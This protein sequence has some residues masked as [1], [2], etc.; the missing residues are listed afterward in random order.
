MNLTRFA[1]SNLYRRKTRSLLTLAAIAIGVA[2]IVALTAIAWGFEASWQKANTARGTDLI[3]TKIASENTLPSAFFA[4][5]VSAQLR[6]MPQIHDIAGLLSEM[7]TVG[8]NTPP[9]FVFGWEADSYLW[10][11]LQLTQG[12]WP[13][14]GQA[15]AVLGVLA[16]E[17]LHK[18]PGDAL[19]IE[20]QTL[21][22]S[23]LFQSSAMIENGAV[24]MTLPLAQQLVDKPGKVNILNLRLD[25]Q[26]ST[27]EVERLRKEIRASLP[28]FTAITSAELVSQNAV[29]R[30]SKAMSQA[31]VVIA[32]LVGALVVFNT[33]LMSVSERT[34]EIGLL[35]ALG[36][37]R[38]S[39]VRLILTESALLCLVGGLLGIFLG[40]GIT[41]GLEHIEL[42][43][44]KIEALFSFS[45]LLGV[46]GLSIL[47][48]LAG[49]LLPALKA[50]RLRPSVALRQE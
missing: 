30:I 3:V 11:H 42:M 7:L 49:G 24:L 19:E 1:L 22:V 46:L 20:G 17:M 18:Q 37:Q 28:G 25:G 48:G 12:R 15:E 36:W 23:G 6:A 39:V 13:A 4:A 5:T 27:E 34:R 29:V 47:L 35:L 9:M 38:R 40:M 2:A 10:Q 45:F 50:A 16:A 44:G 8:P 32:G 43:R 14:P 33:M 31:T 21:V 26:A 41:W